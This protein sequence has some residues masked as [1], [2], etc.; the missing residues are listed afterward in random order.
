MTNCIQE[1]KSRIQQKEKEL[2]DKIR[3]VQKEKGEDQVTLNDIR[4]VVDS[5]RLEMDM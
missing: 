4:D 1:E 2:M 5:H 3:G